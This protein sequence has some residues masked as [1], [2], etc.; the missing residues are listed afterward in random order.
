MYPG[1]GPYCSASFMDLPAKLISVPSLSF[2]DKLSKGNM[3]GL[4][5]PLARNTKS[6]DPWVRS[7]PGYIM[8]PCKSIKIKKHV[9][10]HKS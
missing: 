1:V 2:T 9:I 7:L 6:G 8:I 10:T 3:P 4:G 5:T